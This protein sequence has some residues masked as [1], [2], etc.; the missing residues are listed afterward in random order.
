MA[1]RIVKGL[2]EFPKKPEIPPEP[3]TA[4]VSNPSFSVSRVVNDIMRSQVERIA[5]SFAESITSRMFGSGVDGRNPFDYVNLP[6]PL[7][8]PMTTNAVDPN[9]RPAQ[10]SNRIVRDILDAPDVYSVGF[11]D[12]IPED[13]GDGWIINA[14]TG[15]I[16]LNQLRSEHERLV[17]APNPAV[18]LVDAGARRAADFA[19]A[20]AYCNEL[21]PAARVEKR[22]DQGLRSRF[23][24]SRDKFNS[25]KHARMANYKGKR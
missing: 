17:Q 13:G 16:V 2:M 15:R 7:N 22:D 9:A 23:K 5:E 24:N 8:Q 21:I 19:D 14:D 11:Y 6:S 10:N 20:V 25:P 18:V 12:S 4:S 1:K 3:Q